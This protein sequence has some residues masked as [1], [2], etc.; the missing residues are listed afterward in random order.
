MKLKLALL[1]LLVG[2][3]GAGLYLAEEHEVL[4]AQ[5]H[6]SQGPFPVMAIEK[7]GEQL[8]VKLE[9]SPEQADMDVVTY[10]NCPYKGDNIW[11]FQKQNKMS[12]AYFIVDKAQPKTE[13]T[14]VALTICKSDWTVSR[15]VNVLSA[16][17]ETQP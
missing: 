2:L 12:L 11:F 9:I 6:F 14:Q 5:W 10:R 13:A 15:E 1:V 7:Q 3:G 17:D 16:L 4:A 8:L